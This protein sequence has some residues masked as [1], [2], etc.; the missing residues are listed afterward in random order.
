MIGTTEII[1]VLAVIMF[2]FGAEKIPETA[3]SIGRAV[4]EFKKSKLEIDKEIEEL[5]DE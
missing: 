1:L 5:K 4:G 2:L 3:R